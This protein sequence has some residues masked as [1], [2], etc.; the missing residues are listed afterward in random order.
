MRF[1]FFIFIFINVSTSSQFNSN[2]N[3]LIWADEFTGIGMID[4]VKWHHQ[5]LLPN[6]NSWWNGEQQHYT[7][8]ITNSYQNNGLLTI[9]ARKEIFTDQGVTKN[10]TSARLNSKFAFTY[11]RVEV[12]AK[13]P[14]GDGTWPAIWT[15][16]K[17]I[18]ENGGYWYSSHGT[19]NWPA[20]GEIDIMEHWG[21]NA[22]YIQ[23][24]LH[25]TFSSG[26]T[27]NHGG[28]MAN[29]VTNDFHLYAMEWTENEIK[30]SFDSVVFYEYNP[31]PKNIANWPFNDD[32]YLLIN[33]AMGSTWFTI[34][35][36][37]SSSKMEVD[38]VRV[39]QEAPTEI[40][41]TNNQKDFK[42]YPNPFTKEINFELNV[43]QP[44]KKAILYSS[45][46][47]E[48]KCFLNQIELENYPWEYLKSGNYFIRLVTLKKSDIYKIVKF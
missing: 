32:Q 28:T 30:F 42:I 35:P 26:N 2:F 25:N 27:I 15:L 24:A 20:C 38:F 3:T 14:S 22:N 16:G 23:S 6:G 43:S 13:L 45:M 1:L 44:F 37:F 39:Y 5:T 18:T 8:S 19:T 21:H 48:I 11:G 41:T 33:I 36:F 46:G 17:N 7:N 9:V 29:N 10:Y 31:Q 4:T 40:H 47:Q 12:R 34:D